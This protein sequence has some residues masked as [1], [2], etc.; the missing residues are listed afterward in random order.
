[1][2][3]FPTI[4]PLSDTELDAVTGGTYS[5]SYN[6]RQNARGGDSVS[7]GGNGG[8]ATA[9]GVAGAA[10]GGAGGASVSG[11]GGTGGAN[12]VTL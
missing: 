7:F 10:T 2:A 12:N 11:I 5:T 8:T 1:M 9:S 3:D 6:I 4:S